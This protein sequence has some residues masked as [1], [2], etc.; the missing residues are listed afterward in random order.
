MGAV[1]TEGSDLSMTKPG[2]KRPVVIIT[3]KKE[4]EIW[5]IRTN[6]RTARMSRDRYS[7][8]LAQVR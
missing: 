7:E 1:Q 2:H 3:S 6:L 8:L 4:A 5:L